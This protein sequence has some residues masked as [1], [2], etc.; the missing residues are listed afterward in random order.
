M[1]KFIDY[2]ETFILTYSPIGKI[3]LETGQGTEYI[4]EKEQVGKMEK[5]IELGDIG[6]M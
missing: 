5:K 6:D 2:Y 4:Q 1:R 3:H